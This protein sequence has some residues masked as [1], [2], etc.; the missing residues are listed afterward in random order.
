MINGPCSINAIGSRLISLIEF[1]YD[2][3]VDAVDLDDTPKIPTTWNSVIN[4][5]N[6]GTGD[7]EFMMKFSN[8]LPLHH[9]YS[10]VRCHR[11]Q[12]LKENNHISVSSESYYSLYVKSLSHDRTPLS[13]TNE[14]DVIIYLYNCCCL[15]DPIIIALIS[16]FILSLL[17][18]H[19]GNLRR[20]ALIEVLN[21]ILLMVEYISKEITRVDEIYAMQRSEDQLKFEFSKV[22]TSVKSGDMEDSDQKFNYSPS[23]SVT[24]RPSGIRVINAREK[25][26]KAEPI[27]PLKLDITNSMLSEFFNPNF[28]EKI[29]PIKYSK[30]DIIEKCNSWAFL[31]QFAPLISQC[32]QY[33]SLNNDV[34]VRRSGPTV[35]EIQKEISRLEDIYIR[36][37]E[38]TK[39]Y[40]TPVTKKITTVPSHPASRYY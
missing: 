11:A 33:I 16:P 13:C 34:N 31:I 29:G 28:A 15:T 18:F 12:L 40:R 4:L 3:Y 2:S 1:V 24:N 17:L 8:I 36:R 25:F 7:K 23:I 5:H 14:A 32:I 19:K 20:H 37:F 10:I 30:F 39:P 38:L 27:I 9:V 35:F 6:P 22:E 21:D 26:T